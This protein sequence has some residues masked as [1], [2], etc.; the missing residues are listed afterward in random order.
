MP[1]LF[2]A[3]WGMGF[4]CMEPPQ[5]LRVLERVKLSP[6]K[7]PPASSSLP[8]SGVD[9]DRHMLDVSFRTVR[10]FPPHPVSLD[11]LDVLRDAFAAALAL[12]PELAGSL[13]DDARVIFSGTGD[14]GVT[15]DCRLLKSTRTRWS[16]RCSTS[17]LRVTEIADRQ[18]SRSRPRGSRAATSRSGCGWRTRASLR[19][20]SRHRTKIEV[21]G[22]QGGGNGGR[23]RSRRGRPSV[24]RRAA[25]AHELHLR[26]R[27]ARQP[28]VPDLQDA[29]DRPSG[30]E[31]PTGAFAG[32]AV[33]PIGAQPSKQV[34][35]SRTPAAR[36]RRGEWSSA[37]WFA[38]RRR[39]LIWWRRG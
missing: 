1:I 34:M 30:R 29:V 36:R 20:N 24:H 18:H 10:F 3:A 28:R 15:L 7:Q 8:L 35:A 16:R 33:I 9:A 38:A 37:E 17:S 19:C 27:R 23:P 2:L 11:P 13:R 25:S 14:D 32:S 26:Q 31:C 6:A 39:A 12:F 5:L 22:A 21:V 4:L